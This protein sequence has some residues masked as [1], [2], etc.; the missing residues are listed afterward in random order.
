[1]QRFLESRWVLLIFFTEI[2]LVLTDTKNKILC[3]TRHLISLIDNIA[4]TECTKIE[5][6]EK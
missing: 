3:V 5:H 2:N 4:L 1:M 6:R